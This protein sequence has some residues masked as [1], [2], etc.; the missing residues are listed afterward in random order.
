MGEVVRFKRWPEDEYEDEDWRGAKLPLD[1]RGRRAVKL[2]A[3]LVSGAF[4]GI[5]LSLLP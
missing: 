3:A 4:V 1:P 2:A 5:Y